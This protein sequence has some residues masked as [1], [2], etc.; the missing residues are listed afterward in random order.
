MAV[1]FLEAYRLKNAQKISWDQYIEHLFA[2]SRG[3]RHIDDDPK[4]EHWELRDEDAFGYAIWRWCKTVPTMEGKHCTVAPTSIFAKQVLFE[5]ADVTPFENVFKTYRKESV[6][7][8]SKNLEALPREYEPGIRKSLSFLALQDR[9]ADVLKL[10]IEKGDFPFESYFED[11]ANTVKPGEDPETYKVLEESHF[12]KVYPKRDQS[13]GLVG[14]V[15]ALELSGNYKQNQERRERARKFD[16]G[17]SH[18]VD[19]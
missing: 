14:S 12:R 1:S 4:F 6:N 7:E 19:W 16:E 5:V 3:I 11:E 17:G 13:P 15:K 8:V 9:R 18:P 10:C 2:R